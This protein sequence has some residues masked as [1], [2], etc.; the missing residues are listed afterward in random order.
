MPPAKKPSIPGGRVVR[1]GKTDPSAAFERARR[2]LLAADPRLAE[3]IKRTGRD[4]PDFTPR[5]PLA[6][7]VR[8]LVSQQL[9]TRAADTIH[10]RVLQLVPSLSAENI[11]KVSPA[12]LRAAGLSGQK[13]A[14]LRDLAER[15][16]DGRLDLSSLRHKSDEEVIEAIVAVKGFGRW[17]AQMFLMFC[18]HRP[19]V[20]PTGDLGIVKGMQ[21]VLGLKRRPAVRTMERA[22]KAWAPYRTI[23]CWYVWRS[24]E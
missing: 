13:V 23:A 11:L 15:I 10:K 21:G 2:A 22:A 1:P 18:L 14:Y 4:R 12:D 8:A 24:L 17:S 9:S 5:D 7:L 19:D 16:A 3:V 6:A 20:L